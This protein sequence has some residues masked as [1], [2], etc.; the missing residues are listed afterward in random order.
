MMRTDREPDEG[1]DAPQ[2]PAP[3]RPWAL[4]CSTRVETEV[5]GLVSGVSAMPAA[6]G[7]RSM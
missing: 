7:F 3:A 6:T 1:S 4:T 2:P 5:C